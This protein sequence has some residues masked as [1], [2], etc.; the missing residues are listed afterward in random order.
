MIIL[1]WFAR[2]LFSKLLLFSLFDYFLLHAIHFWDDWFQTKKR[3][4]IGILNKFNLKIFDLTLD[5]LLV[6]I[7]CFDFYSLPDQEE[8]GKNVVQSTPQQSLYHKYFEHWKK[9]YSAEPSRQIKNGLLFWQK[10][11]VIKW[12]SKLTNSTVL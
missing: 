12:Y 7:D 4:Q 1:T 5:D 8:E 9:N 2:S 11:L 10:I 3:E 6:G